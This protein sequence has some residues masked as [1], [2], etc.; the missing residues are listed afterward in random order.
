MPVVPDDVL[1]RLLKARSGKTLNDRRDTAILRIFLD[2][3]CRLAEV[4]NLRLA[5]VDLDRQLVTV[6]G[7][8][9]RIRTTTFGAKTAAALDRYLRQLER[10][11]PESVSEPSGWLWVG[12]Q[13]RMTHQRAHRRPTPHVRRRRRAASA[14]APA[15]PH[16]RPLLASRRW[17]RRRPDGASRLALEVDARSLREVR[18]GRT[19]AR[20]VESAVAGGQGLRL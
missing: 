15:A 9:D 12:R 14:L 8:G 13:G 10:E 3:G 19:S 16:L 1:E 5:D 4:T 7:K 6:R 17:H 18:A 11:R 20:R 2:T